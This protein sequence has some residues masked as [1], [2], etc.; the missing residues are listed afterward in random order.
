M[1]VYLRRMGSFASRSLKQD[2]AAKCHGV[3]KDLHRSDLGTK[4][5]H[6]AGNQQDVLKGEL[7]GVDVQCSRLC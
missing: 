2:K 6:R 1:V 5:Q 4:Q 7:S 3:P